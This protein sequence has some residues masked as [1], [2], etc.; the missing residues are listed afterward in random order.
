MKENSDSL[1]EE[2][3]KANERYQK[4]EAAL[5]EQDQNFQETRRQTVQEILKTQDVKLKVLAENENLKLDLK[6]KKEN[7]DKIQQELQFVKV[8]S[9][10]VQTN[11]KQ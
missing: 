11:L 10:Q 7:V 6:E 8:K 3:K 5:K 9:K 4:L 2:L 1:V